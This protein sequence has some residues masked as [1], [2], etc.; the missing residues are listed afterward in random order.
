MR[1]PSIAALAAR[2]RHTAARFP[3]ALLAGFVSAGAMVAIIEGPER[4]WMS[5][6]LFAGMLGLPSFSAVELGA[7]RRWYGPRGRWLLSLLVAAALVGFFLAARGWTDDLTVLRLLQ[8][9]LLA[10]L[11]IALVPFARSPSQVGFWQLNRLLLVRQLL[12]TFYTGVLWVGLA[13][14]LAAIDKLLGVSVPGETYPELGAILVFGFHPW[15]VLAGVPDDLDPLDRLDEYPAALKVFTQF[16][17]LPLV[18]VYLT[19]LTLYLGRVLVSQIWPSGW[20]GWLVSSVSVVGVLALLL[21]HPI[22]ERVENRWVNGYG[23]W[24]FVAILPSLGMLLVAIAKRVGQYGFTEPR[25]FLLVLAIWMVGLALFYGFSGSRNIRIIPLSLAVVAAL[26]AGGPWG[27]YAVS[28]RSQLARMG[29]LLAANDMGIVGAPRP[30]STAIGDEDRRE[31][32]AVLT[33]LR[34]K[35]GR[36]AVARAV[37]VPDDSL[38]LWPDPEFGLGEGAN[39]EY[40]AMTRLGLDYLDRWSGP[41]GPGFT[42]GVRD[43]Q[44]LEIAGFEHLVSLSLSAGQ[45]IGLGLGDLAIVA[46]SQFQVLTLTRAGTP[47]L[48]LPLGQVLDSLQLSG[49]G[50]RTVPEP[51]AID[52]EAGALAVRLLLTDVSGTM[53]SGRA[54]SDY[55]SGYLLL[56][57][58][59]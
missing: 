4:P 18:T 20:I 49:A 2:A 31:L 34:R 14:A 16:V 23:R 10:H 50:S 51:I 39:A 43:R 27:A 56:R 8:L 1:F 55:L 28:R 52:G 30:A 48:Q 24:F 46:D 38:G 37:G 15:F 29:E 26:S 25:Y 21:L 54:S 7:A 6:L 12:G 36:E 11:A 42:I 45:R 19:I 58:V 9:S 35:H 41:G 57:G 13:V 22:R 40:P 53:R 47:V 59:P 33:Y 32:S 5:R 17:L 44:L 3:L